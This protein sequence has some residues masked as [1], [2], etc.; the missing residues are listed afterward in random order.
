MVDDTLLGYVALQSNT[1]SE[2]SKCAAIFA[3]EREGFNEVQVILPDE[4]MQQSQRLSI[5]SFGDLLLVMDTKAKNVHVL[6]LSVHERSDE[7]LGEGSKCKMNNLEDHGLRVFY[8]TFE[9]FPVRGLLRGV[10]E[11]P[12]TLELH[13]ACSVTLTKPAEDSCR[14]FFQTIMYDLRKLNNLLV[15]LITFVPIQICRAEANSLTV[16]TN[17]KATP[18][19][20]QSQNLQAVDIARSIRFGLLSPLLESWHGRCIVITSM[21]KQS[22]GKSYLLNHL[23][24]SS[25]AIAGARCTDGAWMSIRILPKNVLLV[26][27]DFEGLGSFE[28]TEQEDVFLSVLN[29]SISMFTI[30]RMEMRFDKEIDDLFA[31]FQKGV[32]LIKGDPSLFRG[33]LYMSVKDVDPIDQKGVVDEFTAKFQKLLD[34]NK[35]RNFLVDMYSGKLQINCSPPLGTKNYFHLCEETA[36]FRSGKTF[37]D[38]IRLVLEKIAILGWTPLD[39]A[40]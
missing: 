3:V 15:E 40:T 31:R 34:A 26:V 39:C 20:T 28:R 32:A 19:D 21:G 8:Q 6:R 25:F 16:M 27:L 38:S 2:A 36:G 12:A 18:M 30:F 22:T 24:G 10:N 5:Q 37:L 14:Y 11:T 29:A 1:H 9:K 13:V 33:K 17:G 35:D 4:I 23:T 7:D